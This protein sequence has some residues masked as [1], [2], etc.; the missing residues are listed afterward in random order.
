VLALVFYDVNLGE[1]ELGFDA[2]LIALRN[3]RPNGSALPVSRLVHDAIVAKR[4]Q[5]AMGPR[6]P[7][8]APAVFRAPDG[9]VWLDV[10]G[11]LQSPFEPA[12]TNLV[13]YQRLDL[14]GRPGF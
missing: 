12:G 3:G 11:T 6:F 8:S 7:G 1:K 5:T 9:K 10:I 14:T 4:P 13:V 2:S